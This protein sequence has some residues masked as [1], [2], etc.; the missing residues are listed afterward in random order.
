MPALN[1]STADDREELARAEVY[2]LLARLFHD[3][4]SQELYEQLGVAVTEAP[5]RGAFLEASWVE[6][7]A[8]ARRLPLDAV[9]EEYAALFCG[10]GRPEFFLYGSFHIAG[11]LNE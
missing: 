8:A 10:I 5:A 11:K 7:V 3:A 9:Q 2:G 6:L 1:F 4:P